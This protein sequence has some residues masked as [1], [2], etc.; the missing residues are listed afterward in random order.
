VL[1]L[2]SRSKPAEPGIAWWPGRIQAGVVNHELA[3]TMDLFSTNLKLAGISAPTD[4][5]IDGVDMAPLL[6]GKGPSQRD[7]FFYYR[8]TQLYAARKGPFKA[9][10]ATQS[11]YGPDKPEPH[12]PPLLFNLA[13]DPSERFNVATNHP[14]V[15]ADIAKA[16]EEHRA[17]LLPAKS[18]LVEVIQEAKAR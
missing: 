11:A 5:I 17:R 4:R 18:Q 3:C 16:V 7:V 9:H 15:L 1:P 12:D 13:Q 8:G 10:Y 2:P 14:N 6:F